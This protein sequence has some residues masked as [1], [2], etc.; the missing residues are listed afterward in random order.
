MGRKKPQFLF[1]KD[2]WPVVKKKSSNGSHYCRVCHKE[3]AASR[4]YR[5]C[6]QECSDKYLLFSSWRRIKEAVFKRADGRCEYCGCDPVKIHRVLSHCK[7]K[8]R[9]WAL[10]KLGF[11]NAIKRTSL[12]DCDHKI[13]L[14]IEIP[15]ELD[16]LQLLCLACHKK[17][18]KEDTLRIEEYKKRRSNPRDSKRKGK[19]EYHR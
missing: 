9:A 2:R 4:R 18:T 13:P 6:S 17:K 8:T 5:Y 10:R 1:S 12:Y 15:T 19:S 3:I 7:R 16:D 11:G 14:A